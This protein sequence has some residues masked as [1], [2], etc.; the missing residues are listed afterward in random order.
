MTLSEPA[1]MLAQARGNLNVARH[2]LREAI[3]NIPDGTAGEGALIN[4]LRAALVAASEA[5][6]AVLRRIQIRSGS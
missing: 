1:Y 3:S 4:K 6:D 5:D 2:A